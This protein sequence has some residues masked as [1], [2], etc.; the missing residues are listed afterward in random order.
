MGARPP[1]DALTRLAR[2][3]ALRRRAAG[4]GAAPPV[5]DDVIQTARDLAERHPSLSL[6]VVA[7]DAGVAWRLRVTRTDSGVE[8]EAVLDTDAGPPE[9]TAARLADILRENPG[10]LD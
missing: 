1:D 3:D 7:E 2:W 5:I 8:V 9:S 6:S 4:G 10:I